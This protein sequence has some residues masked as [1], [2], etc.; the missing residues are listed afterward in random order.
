AAYDRALGAAT[1]SSLLSF[2]HTRSDSVRG[3]LD[4]EYATE[5]GSNAA[6]FEQSRRIDDWFVDSHLSRRLGTQLELSAGFNLLQ[7]RLQTD[8]RLFDYFV[9]LD[10]SPPAASG[11]S[12]STDS[13]HLSDSRRFFGAYLQSR[14]KVSRNLSLLGGLRWNRTGESR[15]SR[16][17][18]EGADQRSARSERLTGSIGVNAWLWRDPS[19]D[20]DDLSVYAHLGNAFQPPQV[21]FGPDAQT[22][23]ILAPESL[24]SAE[25]GTKADAL[26]GRL[27]A[28]LA[29]FFVR[30]FNRPLNTSVDNQPTQ[31]AGGEER[32]R[33]WQLELHYELAPQLKLA[34]DF[35][36]NNASYGDF[37]TQLDG[38]STPVQLAGRHLEFVPERV[39]GLGLVWAPAQGWHGSL[40]LKTLGRRWLDP[41]NQASAGGF[42]TVDVSAG[43]RWKDWELSLVGENLGDRRDPV[44]ASELGSGQVYRMAGRRLALSV[45]AKS[46]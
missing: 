24:R 3:F 43:Y 21:D 40:N 22:N 17:D 9:P 4:P 15:A 5:T 6:G 23:P 12:A 29:A 42:T 35:A 28:D 20:L 1:W 16:A 13:T 46:F 44:L 41:S 25:I 2:T 19:G 11:T 39:L 27:D 37:P 31:V 36:G 30:F 14:W 7:G 10:G 26:D 38:A 34:A 32:F 18:V 8:S 45:S 33:G